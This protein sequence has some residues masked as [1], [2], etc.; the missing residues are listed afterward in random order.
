LGVI[1]SDEYPQDAIT[2]G[3]CEACAQHIFAQMGISMREYLDGFD[4]PVVVVDADGLVQTANAAARRLLGKSLP[5]IEGCKGGDVFECRYASLPEGCGRTIHC[6]GC[7]IRRTVMD[8]FESGGFHLRVPAY[9]NPKSP[10]DS[11]GFRY[12]I[13]TKKM[14][15]FVLLRVDDFKA[16]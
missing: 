2:H 7:T 1:V 4:E 12:L 8:T 15:H 16:D 11:H 13:S 14:G 9:L 5:D 3:L 6:S 10:D